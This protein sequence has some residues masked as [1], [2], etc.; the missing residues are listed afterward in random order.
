MFDFPEYVY[1]FFSFLLTRIAYSKKIMFRLVS[2]F[3]YQQ[4]IKKIRAKRC[5][6]DQLLLL[7]LMVD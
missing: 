3:L 1:S 5:T 6:P 4:D 7:L 2:C